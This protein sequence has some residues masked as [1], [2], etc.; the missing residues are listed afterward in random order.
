LKEKKT[1]RLLFLFFLIPFI[2]SG[3]TKADYKSYNFRSPLDIPLILAGNF[4]ELRSNHFH[5]GIDIKTGGVEG[6][7]IFSIDD[8]YISRI[9]VS[10]WGYGKVIYVDHYNGFTSV[11]AHCQKFSDKLDSLMFDKMTKNKVNELDAHFEKDE[12]KVKKGQLIA[13]SGN[14]GGSVAPHLHFEI[15]ETVSER[16]LN[17][18]LFNF[19]IADTRKPE[20]RGVKI[21][22]LNEDN[23]IIPGKS[24]Y[25]R[26]SPNGTKYKCEQ[27]IHLNEGDFVVNGKVG[28]A[29]DVI[30]RLNDANN[31]C[32]IYQT[33]LS[34][35]AEHVYEFNFEKLD[36]STN[37]KINGHTDV[38]DFKK[39]RRNLHKLFSNPITTL[40]NYKGKTN[41]IPI[42]NLKDTNLITFIAQDQNGNKSSLIDR[43][44]FTKNAPLKYD[45]SGYTLPNDVFS[46]RNDEFEL[47][48]PPGSIFEPI[49]RDYKEFKSQWNANSN[50][51][52]FGSYKTPMNNK[53]R[54][55]IN[56]KSIKRKDKLVI[57]RANQKDR[58]YH[59]IGGTVNGDWIET[60]SK[61]LGDFFLM[62][63]T[64]APKIT[65]INFGTGNS[66]SKR[67]NLKVKIEDNLSGIKSYEVLLNGIFIP[68]YFNPRRSTFLIPVNKIKS[69]GKI[70]LII[71]VIDG[72]S[73]E[74][75]QKYQLIK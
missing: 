34:C 21:Y 45:F 49:L 38:Y 5:T 47:F 39:N 32:G 48:L 26:A 56:V 1:V 27:Q 30:D 61:G 41:G 19:K 7:R 37:R 14:T 54:V 51:H 42:R 71:K 10:P 55:R 64:I 44:S 40:D 16:P 67:T 9:K 36:F 75:T 31:V 60:L 6:Q 24:K 52:H 22:S 66:I 11:Y 13:I 2:I 62:I 23:F 20:I 46:I 57:C 28:F 12:L 33:S 63:D 59:S 68:A 53:I 50:Q 4:A 43:F 18:L 3:Q 69:S 15:R 25:Y 58:H 35:N 8:G 70:E 65:P 29:L 74:T 73:N 17:P 72:V